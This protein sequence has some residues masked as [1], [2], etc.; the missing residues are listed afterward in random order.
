MLVKPRKKNLYVYYIWTFL[1]GIHLTAKMFCDLSEPKKF[2]PVINSLCKGYTICIFE[3]TLIL[4]LLT[5]YLWTKEHKLSSL[6]SR[7]LIIEL[8]RLESAVPSPLS[9]DFQK[10]VS[11]VR[12]LG[13]KV[14][15]L[16]YKNYFSI[17]TYTDSDKCCE[18]ILRATN[19]F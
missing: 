10:N 7:Q 3:N 9:P 18:A 8:E 6:Y 1:W 15:F 14:I 13:Q 2:S 11:E 16:H 17:Q 19:R 12:L 5:E 4:L